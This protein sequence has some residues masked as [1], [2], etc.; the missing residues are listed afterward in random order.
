MLNKQ[1]LIK[2]ALGLALFSIGTMAS[3]ATV[4]GG[5]FTSPVRLSMPPVR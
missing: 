1:R 2:S 5:Q 4:T 3:A